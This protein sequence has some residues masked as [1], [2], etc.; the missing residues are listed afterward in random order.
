ML[1][2]PVMKETKTQRLI[3]DTFSGY[4]RNL[5]IGDGEFYNTQNLSTALHPVFTNRKKR[6]LLR[7]LSAPGG[8][9]AKEKLAWADSGSLY[10]DGAEVMTGLTAGRKQLVSFGAYIIVFP[11]KVYYNTKEP[12]DQGTL[13]TFLPENMLNQSGAGTGYAIN[14]TVKEPLDCDFHPYYELPEENDEYYYA[15]AG[16][17]L[18]VNWNT[19][20]NE[21]IHQFKAGDQILFPEEYTNY[22]YAYSHEDG[23]NPEW[24][25]RNPA[26]IL[27]V[28]TADYPPEVPVRIIRADPATGEG[29]Y[30][31]DICRWEE[32]QQIWY[33]ATTGATKYYLPMPYNRDMTARI[34]PATVTRVEVNGVRQ[35]SGWSYLPQYG[36]VQFTTAPP[37]GEENNV[38]I[39]YLVQTG[40][41]GAEFQVAVPKRTDRLPY[42]C[43]TLQ[44][45]NV[46]ETD[47]VIECKNRLW[48]CRYGTNGDEVINEVYGSAL[49]NFKHWRLYEGLASDAWAGSVGSDG[50]WTG[51]VNY[52]GYPTFFKEDRIH[53]VAVSAGGAHEVT[54]TVCEGVQKGSDRSLA[55]INGLLYYKGPNNVCIYQG[56]LTPSFI[57][58][59]LGLLK[60]SDA[61]AGA[62]DGYYYLSM[63][64]EQD[65]YDTFVFD[66]EHGLWVREDG[67]HFT[68]FARAGEELYGLT[69]DGKLWSLQA[70]NGTLEEA[71]SW[72]AETGVLYYEYPDHK[73][74]S[75][76]D[77]RLEMEDGSRIRTYLEY[78][79]SGRWLKAG[80][81]PAGRLRS[82][83]IPV[84]PRRFDHLRM[85]IEGT[86]NVRIWS[87]ARI[88]ETG[89]DY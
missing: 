31:A 83:T 24:F 25:R 40:G 87:I 23:F 69:E 7:E 41:Y 72:F 45:L 66:T 46:P 50:P 32:R 5:K 75:R 86:G 74:V 22:E 89:S 6:G 27:Q 37:A 26:T 11:D 35:T 67:A 56:G 76:Y 29:V 1:Y 52:L 42:A 33:T 2:Y 79:S 54:E 17:K 58:E 49:G 19:E 16:V 63:K 8:L 34:I 88:L 70:E 12:A 3:T 13:E 14:F 64:N 60:Y 15:W 55:V 18:N 61:S 9:L 48:G 44:T 80:E 84:R 43:S 59:K 57:S 28:R 51:A 77:I 78:D 38:R 20:G 71:V 85:R 4:N 30:N 68:D 10:Y 36:Y 65:G 82:V 81:M 21:L 39:T 47:F 62:F 73:Y 53:R